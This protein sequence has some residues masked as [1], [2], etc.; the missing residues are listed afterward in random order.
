MN[1]TLSF[2]V[3]VWL[4]FFFLFTP[5][6][7]LSMFLSMTKGYTEIQR[8]KLTL[9]ISSAVG[10]SCLI[11]FLF[12]NVIFSVFGITLDSFRVGAGGL[13]FLSAVALV[14]GNPATSKLSP[15]EDIAVVP[16]AMPIIVGPATIG[17][18]LVLGAE[19]TDAFQKGI[20]CL[21]LLLAV[22]S[23]GIILLLASFFERAV[24]KRGLNVLSKL[25]GLILAA[26]AAQMILLGVQH[27]LSVK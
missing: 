3:S 9:H 12:G 21:A 14:Q 1:S 16:L 5:F 7:A 17:T 22:I 20:G 10:I 25:S 2:F 6:T 26:L 4:K 18:L 24:G 23:V 8:R 11:L 27:F 19:I 15:E 13:L